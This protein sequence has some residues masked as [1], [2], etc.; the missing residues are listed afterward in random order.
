M[1]NFNISNPVFNG[2]LRKLETTDPNHADTFNTNFRQ[3]IENDQALNS[4]LATK[5][6]QISLNN[7]TVQRQSEIAI[8]R[9]RID[10][11]NTSAGD[12]YLKCLS[13]DTGA[14]LVVA[15]GATTGQINLS[16]VTPR[17]DTYSPVVGDYVR[18]VSNGL[19]SEI[20]DIRTGITNNTYSIAGNLVR[21]LQT[22]L[23][24]YDQQISV[25]LESSTY[26]LLL[27]N[28]NALNGNLGGDKVVSTHNN[29]FIYIGYNKLYIDLAEGWKYV[30][31]FSDTPTYSSEL[32]PHSTTWDNSPFI[33]ALKPY[34][35]LKF[36]KFDSSGN[37]LSTTVD[38]FS[39]TYVVSRQA[40]IQGAIEKSNYHG[41]VERKVLYFSYYGD[42]GNDGLSPQYPKKTF[43]TYAAIDGSVILLKSGERFS[44]IN[45]IT[46]ATNVEVSTYGGIQRAVID[47]IK[48]ASNLISVHDAGNNIYKATT[49]DTNIGFVRV[50][51]LNN[52]Q[53]VNSYAEI[54]NN[55]DWYLDTETKIVYIKSSI[56][57]S[58][59]TLTYPCDRICIRPNSNNKISN[60]EICNYS[61]HGI[62]VTANKTN[63]E[64]DNCYLHDIGGAYTS[65]TT[66][67]G[68]G[69]EVSLY[70]VNDIYVTKNKLSHCF[71]AGVT[72]QAY[73]DGI[74]DSG[75]IVFRYNDVGFCAYPVEYFNN[76][77]DVS[78]KNIRFYKNYVHDCVDISNGHRNVTVMALFTLWQSVGVN[79]TIYI[80]DNIAIGSVKYGISFY[81]ADTSD[82]YIFNN[83]KI[84]V[85]YSTPILNDSW[86]S[87]DLTD[88]ITVSEVLT[89]V[90]YA[91]IGYYNA[92]ANSMINSK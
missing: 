37:Q 76:F 54:T 1:A 15:S 83:N 25:P 10:T 65:G 13:T 6:S 44:N 77:S 2:Q 71:D 53:R 80:E 32:V 85:S 14:L 48:T 43:E 52:W 27:T 69:I 5:A 20:I 73:T 58:G 21:E 24:K 22:I 42:D 45:M 66:R 28:L 31:Y 75:N 88:I 36:S 17:L 91:I 70:N 82:R 12:Y 49:T 84:I 60:I 3:L 16:S 81:T 9:A 62:Q 11:I 34:A 19:T 30:V 90:D 46:F 87:G 79:D 18:K 56:N 40:P 23:E 72:A 47:G 74:V 51:E 89:T 39:G 55:N 64:V 8:E 86:Y 38:E 26:S 4:G 57:I 29:K 35:R 50:N 59:K 33:T 7:E 78:C 63:V 67:Y 41:S 92:K 61:H 68:N